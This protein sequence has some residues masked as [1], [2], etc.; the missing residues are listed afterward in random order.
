MFCTH[1]DYGTE[2]VPARE[3]MKILFEFLE[4]LKAHRKGTYEG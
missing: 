3:W 1:A 2:F 4:V